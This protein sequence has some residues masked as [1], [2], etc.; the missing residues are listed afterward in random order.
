MKIHD[1]ER[2]LLE[3]YAHNVTQY[4]VK[5]KYSLMM[6]SSSYHILW[7]QEPIVFWWCLVMLEIDILFNLSIK[8]CIFITTTTE[9]PKDAYVL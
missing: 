1:Y 9:T 7:K 3:K 2:I 8:Y 4:G 6:M 5:R